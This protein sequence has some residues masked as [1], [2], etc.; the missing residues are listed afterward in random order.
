[1]SDTNRAVVMLPYFIEK[2]LQ[3]SR[4]GYGLICH[5]EECSHPCHCKILLFDGRLFYIVKLKQVAN[6]YIHFL[7]C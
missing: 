1:M 7:I 5:S 2:P 6:F 4:F 3:I